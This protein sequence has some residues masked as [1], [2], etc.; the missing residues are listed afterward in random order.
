MTILFVACQDEERELLEEK[1]ICINQTILRG[2]KFSFEYEGFKKEQ[3]DTVLVYEKADG[4]VVDSFFIYCDDYDTNNYYVCFSQ[5]FRK[6]NEFDV[7]ID[8]EPVHTISNMHYDVISLRHKWGYYYDHNIMD[9]VIDE[10]TVNCIEGYKIVKK[11]Q[12]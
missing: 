10:D 11:E 1:I 8:G 5:P 9:A 12:N 7:F 6:Y 4:I 3:I 2:D